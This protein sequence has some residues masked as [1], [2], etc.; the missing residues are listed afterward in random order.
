MIIVFVSC[1]DD[2]DLCEE[3]TVTTWDNGIQ[4][5]IDSNCATEVACHGAGSTN[6]YSTYEGIEPKLTEE[7]FEKR[8]LEDQ[9]MPPIGSLSEATLQTLQCWADNGYPES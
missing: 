2:M 4:E 1:G 5:I 3:Q 9:N 8:V 6:D 7:L